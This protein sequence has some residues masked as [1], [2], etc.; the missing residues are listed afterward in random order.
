ML[1]ARMYPCRHACMHA[2][3]HAFIYVLAQE[4]NNFQWHVLSIIILPTNTFQFFKFA[5]ALGF[6]KLSFM[7]RL[8]SFNLNRRQN[9]QKT[10]THIVSLLCVK[11]DSLDII[12]V[13]KKWAS[14]NIRLVTSRGHRVM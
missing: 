2:G 1:H 6:I 4:P 10:S 3:I 8:S 13:N 12:F 7:V 11:L 9:S 5:I 14:L